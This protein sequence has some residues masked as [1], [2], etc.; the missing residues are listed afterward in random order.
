[1]VQRDRPLKPAAQKIQKATGVFLEWWLREHLIAAAV[2]ADRTLVQEIRYRLKQSVEA[3][4][5]R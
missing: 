4:Q 3:E 1:M 5:Q 2:K